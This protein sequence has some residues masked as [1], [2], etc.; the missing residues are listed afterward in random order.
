MKTITFF[1]IPFPYSSFL[2]TYT[3]YEGALSSSGEFFALTNDTGINQSIPIRTMCSNFEF[4]IEDSGL[5]HFFSQVLTDVVEQGY[6]D[7]WAE[8]NYDSGHDDVIQQAEF[9]DRDTVGVDS[10]V[11]DVPK[12]IE[13][14]RKLLLGEFKYPCDKSYLV[15]FVGNDSGMEYDRHSADILIQFAMFGCLKYN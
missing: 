13:T 3:P 1:S 5:T 11:I 2:T 14:R 10:V 9:L 6:C 4:L 7:Y 15:G 8:V 12:L